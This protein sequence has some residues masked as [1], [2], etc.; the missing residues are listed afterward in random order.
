M[1]PVPFSAEISTTL[2]PELTG[3]LRRVDL[4]AV[5]LDD[6][7]HVDGDDDRNAKL[8]QLGRQVQ[9]ALQVRA[10]DDVQNRVRALADQ[11]VTGNDFLQRVRGKGIDA[12]KV[13]DDDVVMLFELAF[14]LLH[15]DARPVADE[16]VG[17]G[18]RIEQR[19]FAA[20]RVARKGNF[21]LLYPYHFSSFHLSS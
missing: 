14:L 1:M 20:V 2:Q 16:L 4:V 5:F 6:V 21:D 10:V 12:R 15:R 11:I 8:G 7:H 17:A 3:Q 19:C 9:V 18:Q 13:G